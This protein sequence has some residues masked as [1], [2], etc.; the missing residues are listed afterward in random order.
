MADEIDPRGRNVMDPNPSSSMTNAIFN[1][2]LHLTSFDSPGAQLIGVR[3][4]GSNFLGRCRGVRMTL[5]AKHKLGFIDGT[6]AKPPLT[7]DVLPNWIR[8][9]YMI[10]CWIINSM[11]AS[12]AEGFMYV[13]SAKQLWE[14]IFERYGQGN[15]P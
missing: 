10:R 8:C 15:G 13:E 5:R 3:L 6:I 11:E 12:I 9:D 1:D 7:S 4:N 2:P 14:E